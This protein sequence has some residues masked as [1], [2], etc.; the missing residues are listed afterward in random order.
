MQKPKLFPE[1]V[2]SQR[3]RQLFCIDPH[4]RLLLGHQWL[5]K[6]IRTFVYTEIFTICSKKMFKFSVVLM[7][8]ERSGMC[9]LAEAVRTLKVLQ[10]LA[11]LVQT[12]PSLLHGSSESSWLF[13]SL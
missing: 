2:I 13:Y 5:V 8:T 1:V 6:L 10:L 3:R 7:S 9:L 4:M 11:L 12:N